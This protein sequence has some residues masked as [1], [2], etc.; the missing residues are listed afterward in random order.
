[1][2]GQVNDIE[3]KIVIAYPT[4][5]SFPFVNTKSVGI[6]VLIS[7]CSPDI[8]M[9]DVQ[10]IGDFAQILCESV[11]EHYLNVIKIPDGPYKHEASKGM[12]TVRT[13]NEPHEGL[14]TWNDLRILSRHASKVQSEDED[15][16]PEVAITLDSSLLFSKNQA[17]LWEKHAA[18]EK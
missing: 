2:R 14:I 16:K 8:P 17:N 11:G 5:D 6:I 9:Y 4:F 13:R 7:K 18:K 10:R 15:Q 12:P 1:M 3:I